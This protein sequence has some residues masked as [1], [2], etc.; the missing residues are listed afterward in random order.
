MI[1][2]AGLTPAWQQILV[3]ESLELGEVNRARELLQQGQPLIQAVP[4]R[5]RID[6]DLF[7]RGGL[8]ILDEI[9]AIGYRVWETRPV[10]SSRAKASLLIG[11]VL[12]IGRPG[13]SAR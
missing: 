3:F 1:V 10:V 7:I 12:G 11:S 9:E 8:R 13:H 4:G 2:A 6:V 5:L